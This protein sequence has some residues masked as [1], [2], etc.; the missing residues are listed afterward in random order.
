M[1][2]DQQGAAAPISA[3]AIRQLNPF[4]GMLQVL[5]TDLA[6]AFSNN[7]V[8]WRIQV[9]GDRPEHTWHSADRQVQQQFYPGDVFFAARDRAAVSV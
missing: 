5:E 9:V 7:G 1:N 2:P 6:R 3:Y 4:S 8:L